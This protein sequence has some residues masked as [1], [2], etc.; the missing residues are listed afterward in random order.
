MGGM[1]TELIQAVFSV[2]MKGIQDKKNPEVEKLIL[3]TLTKLSEE[4][5]HADAITASINTIEFRLR[6]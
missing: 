2:G 5:F 6:E 3:D 4:G 1:S